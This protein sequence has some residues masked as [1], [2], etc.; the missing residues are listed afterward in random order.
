MI[1][2]LK[3]FHKSEGNEGL[4]GSD[5]KNSISLELI[6]LK[7]LISLSELMLFRLPFSGERVDYYSIVTMSNNLNFFILK[8]EYE[9]LRKHLLNLE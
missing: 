5:F 3:Y 2:K 8:S 1:Y 9:K 6:N 4:C 7:L